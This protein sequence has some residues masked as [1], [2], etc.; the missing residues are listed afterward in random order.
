MQNYPPT[1]YVRTY[2]S[3]ITKQ[4]SQSDTHCDLA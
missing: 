3:G 2:H 1:S 4:V